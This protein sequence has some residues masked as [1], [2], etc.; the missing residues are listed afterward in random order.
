MAYN[1]GKLVK[2]FFK[3]FLRITITP[4][5]AKL[6]QEIESSKKITLTQKEKESIM[7]LYPPVVINKYPDEF[8]C[9]CS[10]TREA[11]AVTQMVLSIVNLSAYTRLHILNAKY[12]KITVEADK[13]TILNTI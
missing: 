13:L 1:T 6:F 5:L 12:T 4:N 11:T 2:K 8:T 9:T 7:A 3:A 10:I